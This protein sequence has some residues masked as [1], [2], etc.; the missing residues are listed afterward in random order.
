MPTANLHQELLALLDNEQAVSCRNL[1]P[2]R[3]QLSKRVGSQSSGGDRSL[4]QTFQD[5]VN[6]SADCTPHGKCSRKD[7]ARGDL[8][9]VR[10]FRSSL[11]GR[12]MRKA[13]LRYLAISILG[14]FTFYFS[15]MASNW[16]GTLQ[17]QLPVDSFLL[18]CASC[19]DKTSPTAQFSFID[20]AWR[21]KE[22]V[23]FETLIPPSEIDFSI[24]RRLWLE[25]DQ[26]CDDILL[27]LPRASVKQGHA[28]EL[29]SYLLAALLA[30][31][32]GKAMVILEAP[33]FETANW[34][35]CPLNSFEKEAIS[36]SNEVFPTGLSSLIQ[37]PRWLSRGCRIPCQTSY[38]YLKWNHVSKQDMKQVTCQNDN[39]R[40][41]IV[42]AVG[43]EDIR[44]YFECQWKELMLECPSAIA[45]EWALRLGANGYEAKTFAKLQKEENMWD[46]VSALVARAG[47]IRFQPWIAR[48]VK[49]LINSSELPLKGSYI[50][51]Y[52][53]R[54]DRPQAESGVGFDTIPFVNYLK[55]LD[56]ADCHEKSL[57]VY[58]ATDDP[59]GIQEE[60]N[61]LP[62]QEC[63]KMNFILSPVFEP[64]HGL[65][66]DVKT[67]CFGRHR[68][69]VALIADLMILSKCDTFV[70]EFNT[71]YGRLVR[72]FRTVVNNFPGNR[73]DGPI[74]A[75]KTWVS[76]G[77]IPPGP[78]GL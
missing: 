31:Y 76:S 57:L 22:E 42:F 10:I 39:D 12:W 68:L 34:F 37:H 11:N 64:T 47:I 44:Q 40:Q 56:G 3:Q 30:T 62:L 74:L 60:I 61:S 63:H 75:R 36:Q 69:N 29:N 26:S 4:P 13:G 43:G 70:G 20:S 48:D 17:D 78:P 21:G 2:P 1:P 35:D 14:V 51:I 28:T 15:K 66:V 72:I 6:T 45:Y 24:Q 38:D 50:A 23:Q 16:N 77:G 33:P 46:F 5:W 41:A 8:M 54:G 7:K 53:H 27:Y 32:M 65:D 71:N 67:D 55:V 52:V 73:C 59:K 58:V 9:G 19:G 49:A 25:G 18:R